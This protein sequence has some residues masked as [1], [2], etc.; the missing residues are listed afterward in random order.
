M[1]QVNATITVVLMQVIMTLIASTLFNF[2]VIT[3]ETEL[4][5]IAGITISAL[6]CHGLIYAVTSKQ[7]YYGRLNGQYLV[8]RFEFPFM[9]FCIIKFPELSYIPAHVDPVETGKIHNR[10]NIIIKRADEGGEFQC[11]QYKSWF[12]GRVIYFKPSESTHSVTQITKGERLVLS[13][14]WLTNA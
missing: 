9:D 12:F 10:L 2:G 6:M 7:W 14:G 5:M 1:T 3:I 4:Y 11:D 8:K 13:F